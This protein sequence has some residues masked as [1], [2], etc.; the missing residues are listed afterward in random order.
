MCANVS[1]M[2]AAGRNWVSPYA[3]D[4]DVADKVVKFMLRT[5]GPD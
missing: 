3:D 4:H 1:T 2:I 5:V